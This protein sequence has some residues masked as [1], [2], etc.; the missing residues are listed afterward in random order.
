MLAAARGRVALHLARNGHQVTGIDSDPDLVRALAARARERSLL[1]LGRHSNHNPAKAE[2][3]V[4]DARSFDLG[5][6]FAL[7]IAPMQVVQLLGG[8]EGRAK[9]LARV[10]A[11][12]QPGA[13]FAAA[14]ADPF[15]GFDPE[16]AEPPLPDVREMDGWVL[17]SR[18]VAIRTTEGGL[19]IDRYRQAVTPDGRLT[20]AVVTIR[21]DSVDAP[22]LAEEGRA[23]GLTALEP[24]RV[25]ETSDHVGSTVVLLRC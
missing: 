8:P 4:A 11:H 22:T 5:R 25:P 21:L 12:L 19:E 7:A 16:T 9:M 10:R 23:A 14:V 2:G 6:R 15:E 20:E 13:L 18:P 3:V 1:D 24:R 17:S